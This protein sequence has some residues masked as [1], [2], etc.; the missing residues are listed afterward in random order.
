MS[1]L[2]QR[3]FAVTDTLGTHYLN[4]DDVVYLRADQS[5]CYIHYL[6]N[7]VLQV[8][9]SSKSMGHHL[10]LHGLPLFALSR[11]YAVN[12]N[13][14]H[15]VHKDRTVSMRCTIK[16]LLTVTIELLPELKQLMEGSAPVPALSTPSGPALGN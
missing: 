11:S 10:R 3:R 8:R 15:A 13:H 5:Y 7:G 2:N 9:H 12:L 16:D 4:M 14:V 6:D 1:Y